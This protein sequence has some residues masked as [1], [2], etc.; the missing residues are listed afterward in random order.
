VI[1]LPTILRRFSIPRIDILKIDIEGAESAVLGEEALAWLP[2]IG[3]LIIEIHGPQAMEMVS[4]TLA[5]AGFR[6][7]QF[8]SV[9]YCSPG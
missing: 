6:M 7:R 8:R 5:K 2:S 1:S 9:W 3:M 4:R